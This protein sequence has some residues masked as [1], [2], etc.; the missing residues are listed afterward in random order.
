[1]SMKNPEFL[2]SLPEKNISQEATCCAFERCL[3]TYAIFLSPRTD[4]RYL[5]YV[6]FFK[7]PL[8]PKGLFLV[9][10]AWNL[11]SLEQFS[12][13]VTPEMDENIL[14]RWKFQSHFGNFL[15]LNHTDVGDWY[16]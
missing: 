12:N 9:N 10:Q 3:G 1:M 5:L 4:R 13:K 7:F 6:R 11:V 8:V 15:W 14:F 2:G 16:H